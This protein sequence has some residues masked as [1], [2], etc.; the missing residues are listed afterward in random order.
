MMDNAGDAEKGLKK[1]KLKKGIEIRKDVEFAIVDA[2]ASVGGETRES[3]SLSTWYETNVS[4]GSGGSNGGFSQGT[5]LT[6]AATDGTQRAFSK[7]LLDATMEDCYTSG[8]NVKSVVVSPYVK[9]VFVT[10]MSDSNVASFRYAAHSGKGN[11]IVA[12]ADMYEGPYGKVTVVP[13]RVM[14]TAATSRNVHLIDPEM[15]EW[16]WFRKIKEDKDVAKTGD[17][18]KKVL[19]GEGTLCVKN[20]AGLGVVA[21]V[22]GLTASS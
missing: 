5:G 18:Q 13:N 3:G 20:E 16:K 6:V 14:T 11:T 15:L 7:A 12:T 17:A 21:D 8:A 4:R 9:S 1:Q 2:N 10:F 19:I 22:Y